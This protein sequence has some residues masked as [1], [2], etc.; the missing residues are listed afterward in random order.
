MEQI[1][2][3]SNNF[4]D[5]EKFDFTE[6]SIDTET[7]SLRQDELEVTMITLSNKSQDMII[8]L[9]I[10]D[11]NMTKNH[12]EGLY[13]KANNPGLAVKALN[14][15]IKTSCKTV[16]HNSAFDL[17]VL[18]KIGVD[19]FKNKLFDTMIAAHLLDENRSKSLKVL[20]REILAR[21]VV[22]FDLETSH[23]SENFY[24]YAV[25]DSRNTY[26]LYDYFL[27]S[28]LENNKLKKLFFQIEMPFQKIIAQM[29]INGVDI[30]VTKYEIVKEKL[31]EEVL[32]LNANL[33]VELD[34]DYSLQ[35]DL[36]G[37]P[38]G[39]TSTINFNSS[40]QL[41]G[42]FNKL[43]LEITEVTASGNP[44][45]GKVTIDKHKDNPFVKL[46]KNYKVA[47]KLMNGFVTPLPN[48]IQA[49]NKVRPSFN[50]TGARTGRLS[51]SQP[52]L[53]QLPNNRDDYNPIDFRSLFIAPE[54]YKMVTV[55]YSGQEVAVA[56]QVSRDE[57][58]VESLNNGYDMH[59]AIANQFYN[60]GIPKEA[61]N[62]SHKDYERYKDEHGDSRKKAKTIT[63]G[64]MYGKGAFGFSKDFGISEDEAQE[65]VDKYFEGMPQLKQAIDDS[66]EELKKYGYVTNLAGRRRHFEQNEQGYYA[67]ASFRQAFNFKIQGFSADMLRAAMVNTWYRSVKHKE[68]DIKPIMT[69][70]DEA[71]YIVKEEHLESACTLIKQAFEDVCKNFVVPVNADVVTGNSYS[72]AK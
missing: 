33:L 9:Y 47:N 46:L 28:I 62:K 45:V 19:L 17:R 1:R 60:L 38:V 21:E 51:C 5:L 55:D 57:T 10:N 41:I 37:K 31:S 2:I 11:Y 7:T 72:E 66:A 65:I 32:K 20:T 48:F 50:D 8:P 4:K 25:A 40:Q 6:F 27:P 56:A 53:Q 67:N 49:D 18:K 52:N 44:S 15:C 29:G 26:D 34:E 14:K 3:E 70:H 59:L 69:V 54:G 24:K 68:Y 16:Q 36:W 58:L 13:L 63:F 61:L 71:V 42:I 23:Y 43:G 30:D 39:V 12:D 22:D 35:V 64:L